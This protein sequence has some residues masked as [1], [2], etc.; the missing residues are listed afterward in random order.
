MA[1][2][3]LVDPGREF[4][5]AVNQLPSKHNV[6]VRRGRVDIHRDQ[7]VV[8]RFNCTLAERLLDKRS[9]ECLALA[10]CVGL[11]Q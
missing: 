8:E 3:L 6:E 7:A 9:T 2:L 4:M 1:K 5:G 10:R 11:E